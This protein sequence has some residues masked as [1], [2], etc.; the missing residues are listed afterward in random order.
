MPPFLLNL[1]WAK[2]LRIKK[3]AMHKQP[4]YKNAEKPRELKKK[5]GSKTCTAMATNHITK[6]IESLSNNTSL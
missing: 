1:F 6:T 5:T 4:T 2:K 3:T